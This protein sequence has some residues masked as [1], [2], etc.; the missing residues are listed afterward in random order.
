MCNY[1]DFMHFLFNFSLDPDQTAYGEILKH[2]FFFFAFS[3]QKSTKKEHFLWQLLNIE[4]DIVKTTEDLED[5]KRSR[6][7][8]VKE[9]ENFQNEISKKKKEQAKYLKEIALRE[10][11]ITEKSNR[12]DKSVSVFPTSR[13]GWGN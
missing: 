8:V 13:V 4:N 5:E 11:R 3:L 9:L 6:K 7:G 2:L 10:K 1:H 12:L